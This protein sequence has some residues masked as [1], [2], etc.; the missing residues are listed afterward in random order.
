MKKI[1]LICSF[2]IAFTISAESDCN[3]VEKKEEGC[4]ITVSQD[5]VTCLI[6]AKNDSEVLKCHQKVK[7]QKCLILKDKFKE[8]KDIINNC[9]DK[10]TETKLDCLFK[11]SKFEECDKK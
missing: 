11:A 3:K 7:E 9:V 10:Y 8:N 2:L 1:V 5:L 4:Q 6:N